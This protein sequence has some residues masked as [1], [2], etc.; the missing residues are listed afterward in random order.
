MKSIFCLFATV[1]LLGVL[2]GCGQSGPLF[3]PG[4]PS[5]IKTQPET[6]ESDE[7]KDQD[8]DHDEDTGS[9]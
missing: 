8:D 2:A 6:P 1:L 3:V 5:P 7:D 4:D 9:R